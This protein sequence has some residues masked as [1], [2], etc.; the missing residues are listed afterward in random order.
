VVST[1]KAPA[2]SGTSDDEAKT[3]AIMGEY[4]TNNRED[5]EA[6]AVAEQLM[7]S[8]EVGFDGRDHV[9]SRH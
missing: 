2:S 7:A 3:M 4:T 5:S 1:A 6:S 9:F 8:V